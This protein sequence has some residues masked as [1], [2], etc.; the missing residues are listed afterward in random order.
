M[1]VRNDYIFSFINHKGR[2]KQRDNKQAQ[3]DL[4]KPN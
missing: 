1:N 4:T 3:K 2:K